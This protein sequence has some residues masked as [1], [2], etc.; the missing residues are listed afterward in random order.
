MTTVLDGK[1]R[2]VIPYQIRDQL[3]LRTGDDFTIRIEAGAVV[4]K[5]IPAEPPPTRLE[6]KRKGRG[7]RP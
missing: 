5:K 3:N 2:A 7:L 1:G 4:L 6:K